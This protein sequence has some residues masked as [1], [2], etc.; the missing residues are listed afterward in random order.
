METLLWDV[1][2]VQRSKKNVLLGVQD[3]NFGCKLRANPLV[4][5][6]LKIALL[7]WRLQMCKCA[8]VREWE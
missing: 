8:S 6:C 1:Y 2:L 7:Q 5:S 4:V 3:K